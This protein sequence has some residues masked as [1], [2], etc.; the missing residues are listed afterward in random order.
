MT[1]TASPR[2][3]NVLPGFLRAPKRLK[4]VVSSILQ[5]VPDS[6]TSFAIGNGS[7]YYLLTFAK[8]TRKK[9]MSLKKSSFTPPH[10]QRLFMR[11]RNHPSFLPQINVKL[12]LL[13]PPYHVQ[14]LFFCTQ[15]SHFSCRWL[16]SLSLS[17]PPDTQSLQC[18]SS[19]RCCRRPP[20]PCWL[21][22]SVCCFCE[23]SLFCSKQN[24]FPSILLVTRTSV[25]Q[26]GNLAVQLL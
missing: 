12:E 17:L 22:P 8:H 26:V 15:L 4:D 20:G 13:P 25:L 10:D 6:H 5:C 9:N 14:I 16:P 24:T 3:L 21:W 2:S 11:L 18:C 19:L 23:W 1:Q 7:R